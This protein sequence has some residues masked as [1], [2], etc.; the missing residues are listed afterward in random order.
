VANDVDG[1]ARRGVRPLVP[2]LAWIT[3]LAQLAALPCLADSRIPDGRAA[4]ADSGQRR[5]QT[6][7]AEQEQETPGASDLEDGSCGGRPCTVAE[8]ITREALKPDSATDHPLP[9]AATWSAGRIWDELDKPIN[10]LPL[11]QLRQVA[12]GHHL[13]PTFMAPD[14][15]M[16]DPAGASH[17]TL[18]WKDYYRRAIEQAASLQLPITLAGTQWEEALYTDPT[19]ANLPPAQNPNLRLP[20]VKP[21]TTI[22]RVRVVTTGAGYRVGDL[23]TLDE[24]RVRTPARLEITSVDPKTGA[25]Y[26]AVVKS[27]GDYDEV[28][29][30]PVPSRGGSGRGATW[31]VFDGAFQPRISAFGATKPWQ[32]VGARWTSPKNPRNPYGRRSM[33]WYLQEWYPNPPLVLYLSNNEAQLE[34]WTSGSPADG[35]SVDQDQNY[36]DRFGRGRSGEFKRE[37]LGQGWIERY[38]LLQGAM[39]DGFVQ[40]GWKSNVRFIA[41][42]AFGPSH[43]GRWPGWLNYSL[44]TPGRIDPGPLAW[45]GASATHYVGNGFGSYAWDFKVWSTQVEAM[46]GVF[47]LEEAHRLNP[48]FW[49]EISTWNS[50]DFYPLTRAPASDQGCAIMRKTAPNYS[51]A[52][53]AGAMQFSMWL[54]RPRAVRDFRGTVSRTA[55]S[56]AYFE[57]IMASVDKL[58]ANTT[59]RSFWRN[60]ELVANS[61]RPHPYQANIPAEYS[62]VPRMFLLD[63]NLDPKRPWS[64]ETPIPVFVMAR[65]QG[66]PPKRRWLVY[67]Q[68]PERDRSDVRVSIPGYRTIAA[69]AKIGGAF[70]LVNENSPDVIDVETG[71][72]IEQPPLLSGHPDLRRAAA[73]PAHSAPR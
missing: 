62:K 18:R 52:R 32:E 24:G 39:R 54:L 66:S 73:D 70:Y 56:G 5:F 7:M 64:L 21:G 27:P 60:S 1:A 51:P 31:L 68:S 13:L 58:Y 53:Y 57:A 71:S 33:L 6:A 59:L 49:F 2:L 37:K 72:R 25:A 9:L 46:N 61:A 19:W 50:C 17:G 20:G 22:G 8:E 35:A 16:L 67:A 12:S 38:R 28:P 43:F 29:S 34:Q 30:Q 26:A 47:M 23:L 41:Y 48:D 45:D 4:L 69:G 55:D 63:T 3:V 11:W 15:D 36:L 10:Y 44:Q 40:A 14:D 42:G 65:V